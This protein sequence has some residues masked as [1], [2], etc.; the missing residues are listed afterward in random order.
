MIERAEVKLRLD[1]VVIQ[2]GRLS[3]QQKGQTPPPTKPFLFVIFLE[4]KIVVV[5]FSRLK[6]G[7]A[8]DDPARR[9]G[10]FA[11]QGPNV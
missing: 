9:P 11:K 2:Q 1:Q 6:G 4:Q 10:N 7:T 3:E 5:L 8:H